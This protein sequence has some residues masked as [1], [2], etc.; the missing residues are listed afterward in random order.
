MKSIGTIHSMGKWKMEPITL[1]ISYS[2]WM[3]YRTQF[4]KWYKD[5]SGYE[6]TNLRKSEY[7]TMVTAWIHNF[8]PEYVFDR[9][10]VDMKTK[11]RPYGGILCCHVWEDYCNHLEQINKLK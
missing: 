4:K 6:Y 8:S 10:E 3:K 9:L 5:K 11:S 1:R 2:K 7:S